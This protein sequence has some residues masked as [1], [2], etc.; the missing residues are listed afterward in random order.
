MEEMGWEIVDK[1]AVLALSDDRINS[2]WR[3]V[4]IDHQADDLRN[5]EIQIKKKILIVEDNVEADFVLITK[6]LDKVLKS[7]YVE[8]THCACLEDFSNLKDKQFEVAIV[9]LKLSRDG[10][11]CSGGKLE[12]KYEG[13]KVVQ[14]L[15]K[16]C[17]DCKV[18]IFSNHMEDE[19]CLRDLLDLNI[20][21]DRKLQK[22]CGWQELPTVV[23]D[24]FFYNDDL[25]KKQ[26][27][28][29]KV[30]MEET[31]LNLQNIL[32]KT[33]DADRLLGQ[34][35]HE[36]K[37]PLTAITGYYELDVIEVNFF[38]DYL[39]DCLSL[40]E[41]GELGANEFL[42]KVRGYDWAS[43]R[44]KLSEYRTNIY[45]GMSE[46]Q[47]RV[48][49]S[50]NCFRDKNC[51]IISPKDVI[52][53]TVGFLRCC[54][55]KSIIDRLDIRVV[56]REKCFLVMDGEQFH[57]LMRNLIENAMHGVLEKYPKGDGGKIDIEVNQ[58]EFGDT[59]I[60]II[61][62]GVGIVEENLIKIQ[63]G[64]FTT[65][66]NGNGIGMTIVADVVKAYDGRIKIDGK[67]SWGGVTVE[68]VF[69]SRQ[70]KKVA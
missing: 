44:G 11:N 52:D 36:L 42:K 6:N 51:S 33:K 28:E 3:E 45:K 35:L 10:N 4:I 50:M 67:N 15:N 22:G 24:L 20:K 58:S 16:I 63:Q 53:N 9:D 68:I 21:I 54:Y 47:R 66:K 56:S 49:I 39:I 17:P 59:I 5:P 23:N 26:L 12:D 34:L 41:R 40:A 62:N 32:A 69:P 60:R 1:S 64:G 14:Q 37:T 31:V 19:I 46:V 65:K 57:W 2:D 25:R 7:P 61:D 27:A 8:M 43:L 55:K 38:L 30:L 13:L 48:N 18:I 70:K 29:Q